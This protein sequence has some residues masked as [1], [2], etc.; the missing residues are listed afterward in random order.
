MVC[1]GKKTIPILVSIL[2]ILFT[3]CVPGGAAA[4][5]LY[6]FYITDQRPLIIQEK[7]QNHCL[8]S[9]VIVFK[10]Y[11][12]FAEKLA[13]DSPDVIITLPRLIKQ[14]PGYTIRLQ[15]LRN[16]SAYEPYVFVSSDPH[17]TPNTIT[18]ETV[19]GAIDFLG[20]GGTKVLIGSILAAQ[21]VVQRVSS[22]EDLMPL[23]TYDMAQALILFKKDLPIVIQKTSM[24]LVITPMPAASEG[25]IAVAVRAKSRSAPSLDKLRLLNKELMQLLEVD[26]WK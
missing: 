24:K 9:D 13:T 17:L 23:I 15:G 3:A 6:V 4:D 18:A 1:G 14:I 8:G 2:A 16:G 10:R 11:I 12:D 20:R 26:S 21:P 25:I 7:L 19:L 5:E 22:L